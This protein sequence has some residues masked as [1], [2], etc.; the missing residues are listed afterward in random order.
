[1]PAVDSVEVEV[2]AYSPLVRPH[3]VDAVADR[4]RDAIRARL[5]LQVAEKRVAAL[6][7]AVTRTSQR[8]NLFEKVLGPQAKENIKRIM[9]ALGDAERAAVVNAKISKN[10][11]ERAAATAAAAAAAALKK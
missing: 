6:D 5:E 7:V 1:V 2:A 8:V 9:V 4:L 10:K 11:R 3:W